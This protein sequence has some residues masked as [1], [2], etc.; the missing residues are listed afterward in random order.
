M[1]SEKRED[2]VS[3]KNGRA[4]ERAARELLGASRERLDELREE[5]R[6][7][8]ASLEAEQT[9]VGAKYAAVAAE[10]LAM[11]ASVG[12]GAAVAARAAAARDQPAGAA[13][14]Q[15]SKV[16]AQQLELASQTFPAPPFESVNFFSSRNEA[17][18]RSQV[19]ESP[20]PPV[21]DF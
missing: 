4:G 21:V 18:K 6:V 1:P 13:A 15:R 7:L 5:Q 11:E 19:G 16:H 9:A 20:S 12:G 3:Y 10:V 14:Q 17:S 8:V 2:T